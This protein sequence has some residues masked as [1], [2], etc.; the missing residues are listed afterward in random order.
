MQA[1]KL[2]TSRRICLRIERQINFPDALGIEKHHRLGYFCERGC[3]FHYL[4]ISTSIQ[5]ASVGR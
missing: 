3:L 4:R 2:L 1:N 5:D